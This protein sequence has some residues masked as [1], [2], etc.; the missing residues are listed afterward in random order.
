MLSAA[1]EA[2]ESIKERDRLL[3]LRSANEDISFTLSPI[4]SDYKRGEKGP[5]RTTDTVGAGERST[6]TT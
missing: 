1:E 3:E 2:I 4:Q 5:S 6:L